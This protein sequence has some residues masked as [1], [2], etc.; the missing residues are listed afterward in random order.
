M[1]RTEYK[2]IMKEAKAEFKLWLKDNKA[3]RALIKKE[4]AKIRKATLTARAKAA[5][6]KAVKKVVKKKKVT[7]KVIKKSTRKVAKKKAAR[8]KK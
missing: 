1:T 7:K 4:A 5:K 6:K 3:A 2:Q 8:K